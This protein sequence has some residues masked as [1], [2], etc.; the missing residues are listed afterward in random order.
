M[1]RRPVPA[2]HFPPA[3]APSAAATEPAPEAPAS[4][5]AE[6]APADESQAPSAIEPSETPEQNSADVVE[7]SQEQP[8]SESPATIEVS[9]DPASETVPV[10]QADIEA[11][12]PFIQTRQNHPGA[13]VLKF[14]LPMKPSTGYAPQS[15]VLTLSPRLARTLANFGEG[16]RAMGVPISHPQDAIKRLLEAMHEGGP[17]RLFFAEAGE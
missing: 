7:V 5:I 15:I 16:L 13:T 12:A 2:T 4:T 14:G 11:N 17:N 9:A 10:H 6:E 3:P 1:P 8:E